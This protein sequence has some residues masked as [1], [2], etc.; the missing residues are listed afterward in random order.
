MANARGL[1]GAAL[2]A[3]S[4]LALAAPALALQSSGSVR[5]N[6]IMSEAVAANANA[7]AAATRCD[8]AAIDAAKATL[9]RLE[10]ESSRLARDAKNAAKLGIGAVDP[11]V[12][13]GVYQNVKGLH[14]QVAS[15]TLQNCPQPTQQQPAVQTPPAPQVTPAQGVTQDGATAIRD[16]QFRVDAIEDILSQAEAGK[17]KGECID[18]VHIETGGMPIGLM[19]VRAVLSNIA[20]GT[21]T[22]QYPPDLVDSWKRRMALLD[23][24]QRARKD[25]PLTPQQQP[26]QVGMTPKITGA[27]E[28]ARAGPPQAGTGVVSQVSGGGE[29]FAGLTPRH[30]TKYGASARL[31]F[32]LSGMGG[33]RLSGSYMGGSARRTFDMAP[34]SEMDFGFVYS[35]FSP[36]GSTGI[37]QPFFGLNGSMQVK[38]RQARAE[39]CWIL[40]MFG[41]E[42]SDDEY[43]GKL[44]QLDF[45]GGPCA[46]WEYNRITYDLQSRFS[47]DLGGNMYEAEQLRHQTIKNNMYGFGGVVGTRVPLGG[48]LGTKLEVGAQMY[49]LKTTL[50]SLEH[51]SNN[52][53]GGPDADFTID[54]RDSNSRW[55]WHPHVDFALD[56][57][58]SPQTRLTVGTRYDH[59]SKIGGVYNP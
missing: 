16:Q 46:S 22:V 15:Y 11:A 41:E 21:S 52:F 40:D 23:E 35:D 58:L 8:G 4:A 14:A 42:M 43:Y 5:L 57:D 31:E 1:I 53:T 17:A 34:S 12:A 18:Y 38:M 13:D 26:R 6:E 33:F 45:Y 24:Y 49:R 19:W 27:F 51:N 9:A 3:G 54:I 28:V 36:N 55:G 29:T 37:I 48:A 56:V 20:D 25:C 32:P 10:A 47:G 7:A 2:L 50:D 59:W 39:L 30:L 44:K